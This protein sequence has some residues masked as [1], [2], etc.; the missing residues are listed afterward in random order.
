MRTSAILD[1]YWRLAVALRYGRP[2]MH[3]RRWADMGAV[4][5]ARS[6]LVRHGV[7]DFKTP[8]DL[9][10]ALGVLDACLAWA[11]LPPVW[12]RHGLVLLTGAVA[13]VEVLR[14]YDGQSISTEVLRGEWEALRVE[15]EGHA[16]ALTALRLSWTYQHVLLEF[17][18]RRA[19]YQGLEL[20]S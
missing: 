2:S 3:V 18:L 15:P 12:R 5:V 10:K 13:E 20:R 4:G 17:L 14:D 8:P 6:F 16:L 19:D 9:G 7:A 1:R 11:D